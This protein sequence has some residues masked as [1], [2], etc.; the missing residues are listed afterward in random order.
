MLEPPWKDIDDLLED[1]TVQIQQHDSGDEKV[2]YVNTTQPPFDNR[3]VRRAVFSAIDRQAIMDAVYYG[4]AP[5]GQ[6]I[7]PPWHWAYDPAADFFPYDPELAKQMLA[8]EGYT[9]DN[10]LQFE[11][12]TTN[13]T[14]HVDMTILIQAQLAEIGVQVTVDAMEKPAWVAKTW[15]TGGTANP[16]YQASVYRLKFGIP[17]TDFSWRI[18]HRD[19]SLNLVGYNQAGGQQRPEV[20]QM[21]DDAWVITDREE[22][23][24]AYREISALVTED[25]MMLLLGWLQNVNL[26]QDYVRDLGIYIRDDWPLYETWLAQ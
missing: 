18:Y 13:A 14:D 10:P 6:G 17:T 5:G 7:F 3:N 1:P 25:A 2:F 11:I 4:F 12:V 21:L 9:E 23:I 22:A 15:P 8:D 26:S 24:D 20:V 19:T 16:A